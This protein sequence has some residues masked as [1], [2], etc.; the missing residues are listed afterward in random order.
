ML[1]LLR[2]LPCWQRLRLLFNPWLHEV[3]VLVHQHL[4]LCIVV[5]QLITQAWLMSK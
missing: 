5:L 4:Y 3:C 1:P 2:Y